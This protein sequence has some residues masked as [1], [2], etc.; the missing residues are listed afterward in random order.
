[1]QFPINS[2]SRYFSIKPNI[3]ELGNNAEEP[4]FDLILGVKTLASIGVVLYSET[5]FIVIDP[6]LNPMQHNEA[7]KDTSTLYCVFGVN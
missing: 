3:I 7:F 4:M 1:M 6:I 2:I 5:K